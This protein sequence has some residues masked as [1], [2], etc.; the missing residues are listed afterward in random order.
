MA[1]K[2]FIGV[3]A[4]I[5]VAIAAAFLLPSP[6][7]PVKVHEHANFLVFVDG[8]RLN[9]S[10]EKYMEKE[11]FCTIINESPANMTDGEKAHMHG[12]IGWVAH[13]H[14]S[15]ATWG[16]FFRNIGITFNSTCFA[17]EGSAYCS[18]SAN[19]LRM[20]VNSVQ[21]N[22]FDRMPIRDLDRVLITYGPKGGDVTSQ[23]ASVP[24]DACI[25]SGKCPERG[26]PPAENCGV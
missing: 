15:D 20:F 13:K 22:E 3:V 16:L 11:A 6:P 7:Q 5:I 14:S 21:N 9:F 23:L 24:D 18:D 1:R 4:I 17:I 10:Q 19:E 25:F 26:Q 12:G 2:F 8:A